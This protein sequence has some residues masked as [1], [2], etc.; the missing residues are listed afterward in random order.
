MQC[1]FVYNGREEGGRQP[2][3]KQT[4]LVHT[5][6]D[7]NIRRFYYTLTNIIWCQQTLSKPI[8]VAARSKS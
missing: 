1:M 4:S 2:T 8:T 7:K 5:F 3:P 6:P